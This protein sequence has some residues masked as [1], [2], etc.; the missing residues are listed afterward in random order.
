M[1]YTWPVSCATTKADEKPSSWFR[2][3]L[4][5]G[6]HM[7]VTGAYPVENNNYFY[8][9]FM[10]K[11]IKNYYWTFAEGKRRKLFRKQRQYYFTASIMPHSLGKA[12]GNGPLKGFTG[13]AIFSSAKG[14]NCL[15]LPFCSAHQLKPYLSAVVNVPSNHGTDEGSPRFHQRWKES[16]QS[17]LFFFWSLHQSLLDR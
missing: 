14:Q 6:W 5:T 17:N 2:V 4:L 11:P 12:T 15:G 1:T 16:G 8:F 10:R 9:H 7:P 3:Q 13:S